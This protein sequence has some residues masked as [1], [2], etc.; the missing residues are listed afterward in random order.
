M[1]V[2]SFG[3]GSMVVLVEQVVGHHGV[4]HATSH[5]AH[6]RQKEVVVIEATRSLVQQQVGQVLLHS[7]SHATHRQKE[8]QVLVPSQTSLLG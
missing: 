4:L 1:G 3:I 7:S 8:S 5:A 6:H 2:V